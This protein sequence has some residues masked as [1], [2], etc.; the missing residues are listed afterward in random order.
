MVKILHC[1]DM[2][3]DTLFSSC[4]SKEAKARRTGLLSAFSKAV[5]RARIEK[6]QIFLIAGDMFDDGEALSFETLSYVT[7]EIASLP[8]CKFVIAG[9]NHDPYIQGGIFDSVLWPENTYIFKSDRVE[10][11]SFDD[12]NT[13]V[14]GYSFTSK[15]MREC[16]LENFVPADK[17][18][19]NIILAHGDT[20]D[21]LSNYCPIRKKLLDA[22]DAD[23]IALGHIH[24]GGESYDGGKYTYSGCISGRALDECGAKGF[25]CGEISKGKRTLKFISP[26]PVLFQIE[27]LDV[28]DFATSEKLRAAMEKVAGKYSDKTE[29]RLILKGELSE[30]IETLPK[31]QTNLARLELVDQ[32]VPRFNFESIKSEISLKGAVYERLRPQLESDDEDERKK[33]KLALKYIMSALKGEN[34]FD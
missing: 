14:Y 24:K 25:L 18:R 12:I 31:I 13:D 8:D 34:I 19:I 15:A 10:K 30:L 22:L 4:S 32:T 9:G 27:Q 11:F 6:T 1:A 17:E 20:E 7:R 29:L 16:P 33:S 5:E 28:S 23:Y 2:H 26:D 3:I 21:P